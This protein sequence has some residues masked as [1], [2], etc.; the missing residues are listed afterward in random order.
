MDHMCS[1]FFLVYFDVVGIKSSLAVLIYW[2]EVRSF[3]FKSLKKKVFFMC[4]VVIIQ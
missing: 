1:I 2:S 3:F 4:V